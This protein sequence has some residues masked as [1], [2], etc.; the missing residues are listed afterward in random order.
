M[1]ERFSALAHA[2]NVSEVYY[3]PYGGRHIGNFEVDDV[4]MLF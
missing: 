2:Q 1:C 4:I 3:R